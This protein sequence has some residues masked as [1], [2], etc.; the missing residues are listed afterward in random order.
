MSPGLF[1]FVNI[2]ALESL[3]PLSKGLYKHTQGLT[4]VR[5]LEFGDFGS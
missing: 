2:G 1:E 4:R 3:I 5:E